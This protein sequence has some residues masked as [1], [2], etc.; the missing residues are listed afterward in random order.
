M[1]ITEYK[2]K[3]DVMPSQC[4]F[5]E[6][7]RMG[8]FHT[9]KKLYCVFTGHAVTSEILAE[10]CPLECDPPKHFTKIFVDI[11]PEVCSE[12]PLFVM[13]Y[14][15]CALDYDLDMVYDETFGKEYMNRRHKDCRLEKLK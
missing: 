4:G 15:S 12:C 13:E 9:G 5:C 3:V 10:D 14:G 6:F 1:R 11:I 7:A 8:T 2:I